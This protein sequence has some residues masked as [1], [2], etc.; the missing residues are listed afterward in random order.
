MVV[1]VVFRYCTAHDDTEA[2]EADLDL[3]DAATNRYCSQY[4]RWRN[5]SFAKN[6]NDACKALYL[7]H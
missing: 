3:N 6:V 4:S 2:D 5:F 1:F 7:R